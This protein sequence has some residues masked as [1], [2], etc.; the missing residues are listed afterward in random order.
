MSGPRTTGHAELDREDH[1]RDGGDGPHLQRAHLA[2]HPDERH[3]ARRRAPA[4]TSAS[5]S[6]RAD[7]RP[8]SSF[9][10]NAPIANA[11]PAPTTIAQLGTRRVAQQRTARRR[12]A[13]AGRA[14]APAWRADALVSECS[15]PASVTQ[16][17]AGGDRADAEDL[18]PP[19]A[20][21][22]HR[23]SPRR[24]ARPGR[25][26]PPAARPTA[27]RASARASAAAPRAPR[28]RAPR[29]SGGAARAGPSSDSRMLCSR[30]TARASRAC[31]TIARLKHEEA[32]AASTMPRRES[33][34]A[35][36]VY[37]RDGCRRGCSS[38]VRGS[39][40]G[41]TCPPG[42]SPTASRS[43]S[44]DVDAPVV[45][46]LAAMGRMSDAARRRRLGLHVR[47]GELAVRPLLPAARALPADARVRRAG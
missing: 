22:E 41:T 29:A 35:W 20:L 1:G 8:R 9:S 15:A 45:D 37:D 18:A 31:T 17:D 38:S 40:R 11:R 6:L 47:E 26:R 28:A 43:S 46:G 13:R 3:R 25:P 24:A 21:A 12:A 7:A 16:H 42:C 33:L 2:A 5:H 4:A 44:P 34:T 14:R 27:A 39:G 32:A 10:E 36:R 23:A 19:D 30:P